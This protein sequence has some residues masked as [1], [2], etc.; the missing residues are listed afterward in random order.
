MPKGKS[1]EY[2]D[3]NPESKAKKMPTIRS[4]IKT[5]AKEKKS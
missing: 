5:R 2:Y 3:K 1:A 4:L